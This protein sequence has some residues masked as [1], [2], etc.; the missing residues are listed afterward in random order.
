MKQNIHNNTSITYH[1]D[2]T[3]WLHSKHTRKP[4][5]YAGL[6]LPRSQLIKMQCVAVVLVL[7]MDLKILTQHA[8]TPIDHVNYVFFFFSQFPS[9]DPIH[10]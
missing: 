10:L 6:K 7:A 2:Y 8:M 4:P 5:K 1:N 9:L 3:Y